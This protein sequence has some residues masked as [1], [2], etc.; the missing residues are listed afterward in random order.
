MADLAERASGGRRRRR[1]PGRSGLVA[2]LLFELLL[3]A[4]ALERR[5]VVDEQ[6]AVEVI[7]L[8]LDA[9]RQ[10]AVA[11]Q[12]E[13][14]AVA[15]QGLDPDP[16]GTADLF[17]EAGNRQ[18]AFLVLAQFLGERLGL[19]IDEDQRLALVF[20]DVDHHQAAMH[21]DLGGGQTDAGRFSRGAAKMPQRCF[22]PARAGPEWWMTSV[23]GDERLRC[24]VPTKVAIRA[25]LG[26]FP[27]VAGRPAVGVRSGH[28]ASG[29]PGKLHRGSRRYPLGTSPPDSSA[30][31]GNGRRSGRPIRRSRIPISSIPATP[32]C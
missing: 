10:Q 12:L 15:I 13:G 26:R 32:W 25:R 2:L 11:F 1:P 28:P 22:H 4:I 27:D 23:D 14:L 29:S 20:A 19:G 16:L 31:P 21:V 3:D 5:Q 24:P 6:L 8:V 17:V 9:H 30:N 7:D 18:A